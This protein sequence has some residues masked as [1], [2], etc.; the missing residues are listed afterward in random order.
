MALPRWRGGSTRRLPYTEGARLVDAWLIPA[1]GRL[2]AMIDGPDEASFDWV[3]EQTGTGPWGLEAGCRAG[4]ARQPSGPLGVPLRPGRSGPEAPRP[5]A[6]SV[7]ADRHRGQRPTLRV[8]FMDDRQ[9]QPADRSQIHQPRC[10]LARSLRTSVRCRFSGRRHRPGA[11]AKGAS[12]NSVCTHTPSSRCSVVAAMMAV[13]PSSGRPGC[14][15]D[16][17]ADLRPSRVPIRHQ[18]SF[19][20]VP[21][22][23]PRPGL[24]G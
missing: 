22:R 1:A 20:T 12:R 10:R 16:V 18:A 11:R 24:R 19:V 4:N 5:A 23:R 15:V 9:D 3:V 8:E 7:G 13:P 21:A 14:C 2:V 17:D 6:R